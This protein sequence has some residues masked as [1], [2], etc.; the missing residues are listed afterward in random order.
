MLT[1]FTTTLEFQTKDPAKNHGTKMVLIWERNLDN[2]QKTKM[3]I[4]KSSKTYSSLV[5]R[6]FQKLLQYMM[7]KESSTLITIRVPFLSNKCNKNNNYISSSSNSSNSQASDSSPTLLSSNSNSLSSLNH[8]N[9]ILSS[10]NSKCSHLSLL[11]NSSSSQCTLNIKKQI[12]G[13]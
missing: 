2:N 13:R 7:L 3:T 5:R 6:L 8:Y 9:R 12:L 11:N 4:L 1:A 10:L